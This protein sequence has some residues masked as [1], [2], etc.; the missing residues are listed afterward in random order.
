MP[1]LG[2]NFRLCAVDQKRAVFSQGCAVSGPSLQEGPGASFIEKDDETHRFYG[3]FYGCPYGNDV[4]TLRGPLRADHLT[5]KPYTG[6]NG[7]Y[8]KGR[9]F[10]EGPGSFTGLGPSTEKNDL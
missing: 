5:G 10:R 2:G 3:A 4:P 7:P 8:G 9:S 1:E 6:R